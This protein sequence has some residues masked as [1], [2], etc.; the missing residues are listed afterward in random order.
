MHIFAV[1]AFRLN[2]RVSS[3]AYQE[4]VSNWI[5]PLPLLENPVTGV[6]AMVREFYASVSLKTLDR[7]ERVNELA[8]V[9]TC[10]ALMAGALSMLSSGPEHSDPW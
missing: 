3:L 4:G 9:L 8:G 7:V 1:S 5:E 2:I 6:K 10:L